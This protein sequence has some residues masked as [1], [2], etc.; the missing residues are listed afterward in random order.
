MNDTRKLK[1]G[2]EVGNFL[3][4][5]LASIGIVI[6]FF[7]IGFFYGGRMVDK[8][9]ATGLAL[10]AWF[11]L[12]IWVRTR[13]IGHL[14]AMAWQSLVAFRL[15]SGTENKILLAIYSVL[16]VS[17]MV[18]YLY[19]L[20]SKKLKWRYREILE[21]AAKPVQ[22]TEDGYTDRPYPSGKAA[23]S[24]GE[25]TGFA[26]FLRKSHVTLPHF[27]KNR[28]VFQI[29][30]TVWHL[31]FLRYDYSRFTHVAFEYDGSMTV[32][33]SKK[34]YAKYKDELS[35][36]RLCESTG[37]LFRDFLQCYKRGGK[38]KIIDRMN[39]LKLSIFEN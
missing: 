7:L 27:E 37:N 13:N 14:I 39:A 33:I 32:Y 8:F 38:R 9:I 28:I 3:S 19:L 16:V 24:R 12:M 2:D 36:D 22:E 11:D 10:C 29:E 4:T 31:F 21:L 17:L 6:I 5:I 23:F 20:G 35:F 25:I 1:P 18:L 15:L 26:K 30:I 34:S